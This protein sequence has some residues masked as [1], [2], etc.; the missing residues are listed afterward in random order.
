MSNKGDF[1]LSSV[2]QVQQN[3]LTDLSNSYPDV[4]DGPV[5]AKYVLDLQNKSKDVTKSYED[6][7]TS[8]D[9]VL[10]E[11]DQMIG[12]VKTEQDRLLKRK[13][14]I[15]QAEMEEKRKTLLTESNA[16]RTAAYTKIILVLIGGIVI[17]I[18][19]IAIYRNF[20]EE[21]APE[22]VFTMFAL[23]HLLN[24]AIFTIIAFKIYIDI[25]SRSQINFNKL[26]LPPPDT[27]GYNAPAVSDFNNLFADLKMCYSQNCCGPNTVYN[28]ELDQCENDNT[29]TSRAPAPGTISSPAPGTDSSPAPGTVSTSVPAP[30]TSNDI[31]EGFNPYGTALTTSPQFIPGTQ[32]D[33]IEVDDLGAKILPPEK[34]PEKEFDPTTASEDELKEKT[35]ENVNSLADDIMGSIGGFSELGFSDQSGLAGSM[36]SAFGNSADMQPA[37]L[38]GKAPQLS[39]KCGF[40]TMA[41]NDVFFKKNNK[42]LPQSDPTKIQPSNLQSIADANQKFFVSYNKIP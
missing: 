24:F 1:D 31:K 26:D 20:V 16:L 7:N 8:S 39:S 9:T 17:H 5:I 21:P 11:Q 32:S 29:T 27:T 12:I 37:A 36:A 38:L 18:L 2:F 23:L 41:E 33:G 30:S 4:N 35:H 42:L 28:E 15:D 14:A 3:Y 10:V 13:A 40:T 22:Y 34:E 6:A 25:Q 19:L